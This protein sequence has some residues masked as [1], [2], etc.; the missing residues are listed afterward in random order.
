MAQSL[1]GPGGRAA[2]PRFRPDLMPY[3]FILPAVVI[4][5][6]FNLG[7]VLASFVLSFF[8]W[9]LLTPTAEFNG[10]KHYNFILNDERFWGALSH[11][12]IFLGLAVVI[13]VSIGLL[14]AVFIYEIRRGRVF[15]RAALFLPAIFSGVVIAYVWKWIYHPFAGV[16]NP[17][18]ELVG[19][20]AFTQSWLG[21]HKIALYSTFIAYTWASFGY[22]MVIFLAG[23]QDIPTDIFDAARV[24][25]ANFRQKLFRV[26]IPCLYDVFTFVVTLR[27]FTAMG[28]FGVIYIL[29]GGGPYYSS[30]VIDIYVFR[31][32][33]NFEM[34]WAT[35]AATVNTMI[36][37]CLS[38]GFIKWREWRSWSS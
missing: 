17:A 33:G 27:I 3:L 18:L 15:F 6:V 35:A 16:L 26:T 29:T 19:L 25:G 12:F 7:P 2:S 8:K 11:N 5:L 38:T 22:S 9:D 14:L 10:F 32:I 1:T 36:V 13:P 34:G 37:V 28:V 21:D 30:D 24:D 31:M 4:Y 23:L 20:G